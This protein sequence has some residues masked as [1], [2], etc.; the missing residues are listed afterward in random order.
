MRPI[1]FFLLIRILIRLVLLF[2]FL[3]LLSIPD[4]IHKQYL[5][6]HTSH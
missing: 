2:L 1:L 5:Q 3:A 4:R 6:V